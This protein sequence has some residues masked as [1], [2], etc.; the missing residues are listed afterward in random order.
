MKRSEAQGRYLYGLEKF[1]ETSALGVWG[2]EDCLR[3]CMLKWEEGM[4]HW[5]KRG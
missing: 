3:V 4:K 5:G 2:G 1:R